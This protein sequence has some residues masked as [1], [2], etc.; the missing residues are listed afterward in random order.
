MKVCLHLILT[1]NNKPVSK[2]VADKTSRKRLRSTS[3]QHSVVSST[4]TSV[5]ESKPSAT[6]NVTTHEKD[7]KIPCDET[8]IRLKPANKE[9]KLPV[10]EKSDDGSVTEVETK[11]DDDLYIFEEDSRLVK[12]IKMLNDEL[13]ENSREIR[14]AFSNLLSN[15]LDDDVPSESEP[16]PESDSDDDEGMSFQIDPCLLK[17]KLDAQHMQKFLARFPKPKTEPWLDPILLPEI[18]TPPDLLSEFEDSEPEDDVEN[19][20]RVRHR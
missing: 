7:S 10:N 8:D 2:D 11:E 9:P 5:T 6:Q 14:I 4:K 13:T 17:I 15:D 18:F 1:E 3:S 20:L 12:R 16:E 19:V